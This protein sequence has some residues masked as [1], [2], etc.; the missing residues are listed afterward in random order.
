MFEYAIPLN[1]LAYYAVLEIIIMAMALSFFRIRRKRSHAAA[2][3]VSGVL[4]F[5]VFMFLAYSGVWEYIIPVPNRLFF[6]VT[7]TTVSCFFFFEVSH[8]RIVI[9]WSVMYCMLQ[10]M[11][12]CGVQIFCMTALPVAWKIV[13]AL[14]VCCA[15][16][17]IMWVIIIRGIREEIYISS[18]YTASTI[19]L[20]VAR[21]IITIFL[22]N[23]LVMVGIYGLWYGF[24]IY[25]LWCLLNI[26]LMGREY[27]D[28]SKSFRVHEQKIMDEMKEKQYK[29]LLANIDVINIK[30]HDLKRYVRELEEKGGLPGGKDGYLG[31]ISSAL[32]SYDS[33]SNTGNHDLDFVLTE[34]KL[35][36]DRN[37]IC[38]DYVI[39][40]R[41]L[42]FMT[43][44][45]IYMLFDNALENAIEASEKE[46]EDKRV[47]S[48]HVGR[49]SDLIYI[50]IS[51][52]CSSA[53]AFADGLPVTSKE[54]DNNHGYGSLSIRRIVQKYS[55][56][57]EFRYSRKY[58]V[59]NAF[60]PVGQPIAAQQAS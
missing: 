45:D 53:P 39:D 16:Y 50:E 46:D 10:T 32:S 11:F 52:H 26:I 29:E 9:I 54:G 37:S 44:F 2:Y 19:I 51:N 4:I 59:L 55:G 24:L 18:I 6:M 1:E 34:K 13:C 33:I 60:M 12:A 14:A 43:G 15:V 27:S 35:I 21:I 58:F 56:Y 28:L 17:L 49:E 7:G 8:K 23:L 38:F 30:C 25:V 31:E 42:G 5:A 41:D 3:A 47:I 22:Y 36:C 57:A 20:E 40:A 48:V